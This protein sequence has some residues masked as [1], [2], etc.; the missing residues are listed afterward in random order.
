L[1]HSLKYKGFRSIGRELGA[2]LGVE[3]QRREITADI[4]IPV[5]LYRPRKRERGYNQA[6][7]IAEGVSKQTGVQQNSKCVYRTRDTKTQTNL[8]IQERNANVEDAFA[9]EMQFKRYLS[10]KS[11]IVIDDVMTTGATM[12]AVCEAL[13]SSGV[14]KI[15]AASIALAE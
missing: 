11:A 15:I 9:V 5:P 7:V 12:G 6:E 1:I 8:N 10:E 13:K 14:K 4:I 3:I 2:K